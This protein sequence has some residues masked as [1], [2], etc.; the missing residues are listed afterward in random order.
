MCTLFLQD[1]F[2]NGFKAPPEDSQQDWMLTNSE[3]Q[4]G[5]TTLKFYRA[6]DTGDAND[7][8]IEVLKQLRDHFR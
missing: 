1:Y 8:A 5:V 2:T 4:N 6:R 7:V 3:E